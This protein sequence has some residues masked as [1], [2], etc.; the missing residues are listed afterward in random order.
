MPAQQEAFPRTGTGSLPTQDMGGG[1]L[2]EQAQS[3]TDAATATPG[4]HSSNETSWA[5]TWAESVVA[6]PLLLSCSAAPRG[7]RS[8]SQKN[9]QKTGTTIT[10]PSRR[11]RV[12]ASEQ[13]R[14]GDESHHQQLGGVGATTDDHQ[15]Q[16]PKERLFLPAHA[17][18]PP[19][20]SSPPREE[21]PSSCRPAVVVKQVEER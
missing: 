8:V 18:A 6:G 11:R 4:P 2:R 1:G 10:K 21:K 20:S 17:F 19:P 12:V 7:G 5:E 14:R 13:M 16:V 3:A 9:Q 15:Q